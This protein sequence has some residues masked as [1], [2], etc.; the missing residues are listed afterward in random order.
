MNPT[1]IALLKDVEDSATIIDEIVKQVTEGLLLE[2]AVAHVTGEPAEE[3]LKQLVRKAVSPRLD[4]LNSTF[5]GVLA[6]YAQQAA[7]QGNQ[8]IAGLLLS[9]HEEVVSSVS[10][11]L[12]PEMQVLNSALQ[13]RSSDGRMEIFR[14]QT[15]TA[16]PVPAAVEDAGAEG[17]SEEQ[18]LP[19]CSIAALIQTVEQL[20]EEMEAMPEIPDRPLLARLCLVR[21]EVREVM[22]E[23]TL[24]A[25][26]KD[27]SGQQAQQ[28][29]LHPRY[30]DPTY[31]EAEVSEPAS[32]SQPGAQ[33][34]QAPQ[35]QQAPPQQQWSAGQGFGQPRHQAKGQRQAQQA[36]Q[37]VDVEV[38]D[39]S[40]E[41]GSDSDTDE[42]FDPVPAIAADEAGAF[43]AV[44]GSDGGSGQPGSSHGEGASGSGLASEEEEAGPAVGGEVPELPYATLGVVP[45]S[46]LAFLK[47]VMA[48][49]SAEKRLALLEKA[50]RTD[51]QGAAGRSSTSTGP[52]SGSS[53]ADAEDAAFY[54]AQRQR[55]AQLAGKGG[56]S[57]NGGAEA[58]EEG[59][60]GLPWGG[61]GS[62]AGELVR[63][64]RFMQCLGVVQE[65]LLRQSERHPEPGGGQS[66]SGFGQQAQQEEGQL[67]GGGAVSEAVLIRVEEVRSQA[68][69]V[70]REIA[71]E[72]GAEYRP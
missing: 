50:F 21:E 44:R 69:A 41:D 33:G 68:L 6:T 26:P 70:L 43:A 62:A 63:P 1:P 32:A 28:P 52:A 66:R 12:P 20:V 53:S 71:G 46:S 18:Q 2:A 57:K 47:E 13:A 72:E 3:T 5:L 39:P 9:I 29:R 35:Q 67:G 38:V 4:S 31:Q 56:G 65:E 37:E 14:L 58:S 59:E 36:A 45:R 64:G 34:Q 23:A 55:L 25:A 22:R 48:L 49:N 11:R 24:A 42:E 7:E 30:K 61:D 40:L 60:T 16:A 19:S 8:D 54:E 27:A 15:R 17:S 10:Q 51:W